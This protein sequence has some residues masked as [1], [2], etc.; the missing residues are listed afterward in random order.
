MKK[1]KKRVNK[2]IEFLLIIEM[3]NDLIEKYNFSISI[4][5]ILQNNKIDIL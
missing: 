5:Y 1:K 2:K 4:H 3:F